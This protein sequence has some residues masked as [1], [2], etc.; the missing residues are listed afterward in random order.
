MHRFYHKFIRSSL[1]LFLPLIKLT[2]KQQILENVY[3]LERKR[4]RVPRDFI[5]FHTV[6]MKNIYCKLLN[7]N[8]TILRQTQW[9]FFCL[10]FYQIHIFECIY[11][12]FIHLLICKLSVFFLLFAHFINLYMSVNWDCFT[13]VVICFSLKNHLLVSI[14]RSFVYLYRGVC[15]SHTVKLIYR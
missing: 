4:S 14:W 1:F 7:W 6:Y 5:Q 10:F 12:V 2:F 11:F 9:S 15:H 3:F 13:V 8:N